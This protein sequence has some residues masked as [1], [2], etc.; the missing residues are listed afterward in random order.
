MSVTKTALT[1][2]SVAVALLFGGGVYVYLNL[3][4]IAKQVTE[5]VATDALGVDV[6][7]GMMDVQLEN[8]RAIV[9][10]LKIANPPGFKKS[11]ALTV[12][13][14]SV[15]LGDLSKDL[16]KIKDIS[17]D[18][19]QVNLEVKNGG[20]N[21]NTLSDNVKKKM[22]ASEQAAE[23]GP[24][25]II[26]RFALTKAQLNPTVTLI[27][28]Q[29]L[30]SV[31]VPD[32]ILTGIGKRENGVLARE[33]VAQVMTQVLARVQKAAGNAGFYQGLSPEALKDIGAGQVE[34]FKEKLKD[35]IGSGA[36]DVE[37]K[38]KGLF[39]N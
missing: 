38:I 18:G 27:N 32:I 24:K 3:S 9:R 17:V 35:K 23:P 19:T 26:D 13:E 16:V 33:A 34:G 25:V 6:S 4:N 30:S 14:I 29:D 12:A 39:G 31:V 7:M 2:S 22:P 1:V 36:G 20:T 8:R 15:T 10:N 5:R 11:H 37:D 21:L 28:D